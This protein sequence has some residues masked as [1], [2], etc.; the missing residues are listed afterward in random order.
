MENSQLSRY[1]AISKVIPFT[2]GKV[3]WVLNGADDEVQNFVNEF[4]PDSDGVPRVFTSLETC[5]SFVDSNRNDIVI[6]GGQGTHTVAAQIAWSKSRVRVYGL[7]WLLGERRKRMQSSKIQF[8]L[9]TEAV[10]SPVKVTGVRNSFHGIKFINNS[11]N[12]A[13]LYAHVA[14]GEGSYYEDCAFEFGVADN[15]DLTTSN[16]LLCGEDS[17]TFK[18]CSFGNMY[19]KTSGARSVVVLDAVSG[20]SSGEGAKG[21]DFTNCDFIIQSSE[22]NATLVKVADTA[23]AKFLNVFDR[24]MFSACLMAT[25]TAV[26]ITN[27]VA[28][29]S[30]L[31]DGCVAIIDPKT[32]FVTNTCAGTTDQVELVAAATSAN[33]HEASTPS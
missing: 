11:T 9:G 13:A 7:D 15:L 18:N 10:A 5:Y 28:S 1:G 23:G 17:G 30:G 33:A 29:S 2:T 12:A 26:A 31:V 14:A 20:S 8:A 3:F 27:A 24:P 6:L 16:E 22:A 4:P 32:M 25:G 21:N 19:L